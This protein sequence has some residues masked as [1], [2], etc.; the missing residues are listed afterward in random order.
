MISKQEVLEMM[1]EAIRVEESFL[2]ELG[3]LIDQ[4]ILELKL[5]PDKQHEAE[6]L[7]R[8]LQEQ[9]LHHYELI[10]QAKDKVE[11]SDKNDY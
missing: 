7:L 3:Y 4:K 9:S 2:P 8:I 1:E 10:K 11:T 5:T 6:R